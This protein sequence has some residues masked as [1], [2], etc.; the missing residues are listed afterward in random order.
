[1]FA[2]RDIESSVLIYRSLAGLLLSAMHHISNLLGAG[3]DKF[4]FLTHM[5]A[6]I[7]AQTKAMETVRATSQADLAA[8]IL[9]DIDKLGE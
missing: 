1:M 6:L 9:A 7:A 3:K 8:L 4:L 5:E 2:S